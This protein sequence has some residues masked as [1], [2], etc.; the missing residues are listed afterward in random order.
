MQTTLNLAPPTAQPTA[1][2]TATWWGC[3]CPG[4]N[5]HYVPA[6]LQQHQSGGGG[7][8]HPVTITP[9]PAYPP[10]LTA[11][12][13]WANAICQLSDI[14]PSHPRTSHAAKR[15]HKACQ[16]HGNA[17]PPTTN[18]PTTRGTFS[19]TLRIQPICIQ[20]CEGSEGCMFVSTCAGEAHGHVV[21]T[22]HSAA[23]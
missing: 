21:S 23:H 15:H 20:H 12:H 22:R 4:P 14:H 11:C 7:E 9:T 6:S 1:T 16:H 13:I 5:Q 17:Q 2:A 10:T 18:T 3:Q 19:G 8:N